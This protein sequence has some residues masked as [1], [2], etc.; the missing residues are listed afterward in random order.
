MLTQ[1]GNKGS[2]SFSYVIKLIDIVKLLR[3]LQAP[4]PLAR[5]KMVVKCLVVWNFIWPTK[6]PILT[7]P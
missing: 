5:P 7:T 4:M 3:E 2:S 6:D 1:L